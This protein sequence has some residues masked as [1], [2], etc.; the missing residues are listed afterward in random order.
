M[1]S[2]RTTGL[3]AASY[4]NSYGSAIQRNIRDVVQPAFSRKA[5]STI[6]LLDLIADATSPQQ[7]NKHVNRFQGRIWNLSRDEQALLR[8]RLAEV[9]SDLVLQSK[10]R[11]LR[12]EAAGWMRLLVQAAYLSEPGSVF[13]TLIAA[14][15]RNSE[16]D[17]AECRDYLKMI[18]DC[19][20]PFRQPYATYSWEKLPAIEAFSPL[21]TLLV[22]N[23]DSIEDALVALFSQLPTL[24]N[25]EIAVALLPVVLRWAK[26]LDVDRRQRVISLLAGL[27]AADARVALEQLSFDNDPVV[28]HN[29]LRALEASH[30]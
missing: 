13:L 3:L 27:A 20:W 5:A 29:A 11:E 8:E 25:S 21:A 12:L 18:I 24:D 4:T 15:T 28:R 26:H 14:A 9:L 30:G 1:D 7:L 10:M 17:V 2:S 6:E 23:E 19:F 16:F 22:L